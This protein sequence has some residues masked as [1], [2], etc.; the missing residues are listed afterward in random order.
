VS[1]SVAELGVFRRASFASV[2]ATMEIPAPAPRPPLPPTARQAPER[3]MPAPTAPGMVRVESSDDGL[4]QGAIFLA[5]QV[6]I[7]I[8]GA[9]VVLWL[10][11]G[12]RQV[13][14]A[15][16]TFVGLFTAT[17]LAFMTTVEVV[18][19]DRAV[20]VPAVTLEQRIASFAKND[21]NDD[22]R[23]DKAEYLNVLKELSFPEQLDNFWVQR[24][25]DGDGFISLEEI[26]PEIGFSPPAASLQDRMTAFTQYDADHDNKLTKEEYVVVLRSLGFGGMIETY[27]PQRDANKDGFINLEEYVPAIPPAA[28]E[29]PSAATQQRR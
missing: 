10:L 15:R 7:A 23:L 18:N 17:V 24:D 27:W 13:L 16:L 9:G 28:T 11:L 8:A 4:V 12:R 19:Q 21:A 6:A 1:I 26:K 29:Q 25:R 22:N 3:P 14:A 20:A 5:S 2:E